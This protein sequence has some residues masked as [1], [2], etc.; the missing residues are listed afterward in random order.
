M[1]K[2][3]E[4]FMNTKKTILYEESSGNIFKD[5]GLNNPDLEDVKVQLSIKIFKILKKRNLTQVQIGKILGI[6]QP[7]IS[8]LK[9]GQYHRFSL[10]RLLFFLNCLHY[11]ID[12]KLSLAKS[13]QVRQRVV[14]GN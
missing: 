12:I 14:G 9:H 3:G 2:T 1:I 8:K 5:L 7:E 13:E 4:N 6:S 11:N 10:E